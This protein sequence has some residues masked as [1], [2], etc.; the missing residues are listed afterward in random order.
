MRRD[1]EAVVFG[2]L[3]IHGKN[4]SANNKTARQCEKQQCSYCSRKKQTELLCIKHSCCFLLSFCAVWLFKLEVVLNTSAYVSRTRMRRSRHPEV[5][6]SRLRFRSAPSL[7]PKA[8]RV[9][10]AGSYTDRPGRCS[11]LAGWMIDK[12]TELFIL[13]LDISISRGK[14]RR[15]HHRRTEGCAAFWGLGVSE[16]QRSTFVPH[17]GCACKRRWG[18]STSVSPESRPAHS[19]CRLESS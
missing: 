13:F 1:C 14:F 19:K 5:A 8:R 11:W 18:E 2:M 16:K 4:Q 10:W 9:W 6:C 7:Y 3:G 12:C 17:L 15:F